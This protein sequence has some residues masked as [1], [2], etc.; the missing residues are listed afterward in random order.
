[1]AIAAEEVVAHDESELARLLSAPDGPRAIRLEPHP[2]VGDLYIARSLRLRG[3][4]GTI[5]QGSG[6]GTVVTIEGEGVELEDVAIRGSGDR[7][8]AQDAAVRATGRDVHVRDVLVDGTLFGI[9]FYKCPSSSIERVHVVGRDDLVGMRGDAIKV[10]ESDDAVVKDSLI[11]RSR[12]VVIWYTRRALVEGLHVTGSRYGTH[13]MYAHDCVVRRARYE[14]DIVGV[15]AM[16]SSHIR[17]EDSVSAGARGAAGM[18]IGFKD[19]DDVDLEGNWLVANTAGVYFDHS[20]RSPEQPIHLR[21]NVLA[22]NQIGLHLHSSEKGVTVR[23]CDFRENLSDAQVDGQG[24]AL[25]LEVEGNH[26]TQYAGYDLD[27]DGRGDVPFQIKK[28]SSD[29]KERHAELH[30][31]DGSFV[32]GLLDTVAEATPIFASRLMLVDKS[33]RVGAPPSPEVP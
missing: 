30:L 24:D 19:T 32:M 23:D 6:G 26:W 16:Y 2:Y 11:E 7:Y 21:G 9:L 14:R 12:D 1:M 28:L 20:P 31:F 29:L 18:G 5:L 8:T 27:G 4:P 13:F 10:W 17:V 3:V 33:P 15:F 25:G 22:L